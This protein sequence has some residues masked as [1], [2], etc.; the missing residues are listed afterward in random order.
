[1]QHALARDHGIDGGAAMKH[2]LTVPD[3]TRRHEAVAEA[4]L[5]AYREND[6]AARR[7][8]SDYFGHARA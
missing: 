3:P 4:L 2:R 8:V 5:T 6:E 7:V 1:M